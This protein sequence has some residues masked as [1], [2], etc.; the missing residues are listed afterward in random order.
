MA[1]YKISRAGKVLGEYDE[2]TIRRYLAAGSIKLHDFGWTDGMTE[3]SPLHELG[4]RVST[5]AAPPPPVGI[6][7]GGVR[8][9]P[10]FAHLPPPSEDGEGVSEEKVQ[11]FGYVGAGLLTLGT[12]GPLVN[13]GILS[14]TILQDGNW[15]G[16]TV[17]GCGITAA[18][19][20]FAR[21]YAVNWLTAIIPSLIFAHAFIKLNESA[22]G[23]DFGS[24]LARK[25]VSPG[26]GLFA[27]GVGVAA[28]II[29]AWMSS[30]PMKKA[31]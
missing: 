6:P 4:F 5:S 20:T 11:L 14:I 25:L 16:L 21:A 26:W 19:A 29:S 22:S 13:L 15:R 23:D 27:M 12:F 24:R 7:E 1:I 30:G 2:A 31:R 8:P 18:T 17:L 28:L 10:A 3:W 9:Q